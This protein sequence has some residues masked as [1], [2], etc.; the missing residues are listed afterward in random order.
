M[1]TRSLTRV[2]D[3]DFGDPRHVV[4]IY[5]QYDG[6]LEGHGAVLAE[7]ITSRK[8]VNGISGDITKVFNGA[9]CFA[10]ALVAHLKT[11]NGREGTI[12]AG[13]VYL[14]PLDAAPE[15]YNYTITI[16]GSEVSMKA[17]DWQDTTL[18]EGTP[19][20]FLANISQEARR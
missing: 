2:I 20:E 17:T 5:R 7:F 9:G 16:A 14:Y 12:E 10:A 19:E 4:T 3:H 8:F 13:G 11:M 15:E 18:F 6:Y 1:G